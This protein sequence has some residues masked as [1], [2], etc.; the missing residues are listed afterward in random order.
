MIHIAAR[1]IG[2]IFRRRHWPMMKPRTSGVAQTVMLNGFSKP[3]VFDLVQSLELDNGMPLRGHGG[4]RATLDR[5][6]NIPP[7]RSS[8]ENPCKPSAPRNVRKPRAHQHHA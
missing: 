1:A 5:K 6:Q 7:P 8:A 3:T 2:R 4:A